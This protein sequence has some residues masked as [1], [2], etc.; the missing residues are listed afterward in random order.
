MPDTKLE[1]GRCLAL[2]G[3][4]IEVVEAA[5]YIRAT[6]SSTIAHTPFRCHALDALP[7]E[8]TQHAYRAAAS[9]AMGHY[10]DVTVTFL[11]HNVS[12]IV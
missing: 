2:Q 3:S 10:P 11:D 9:R 7:P 8:I 1:L 6:V 12:H 5:K 4:P